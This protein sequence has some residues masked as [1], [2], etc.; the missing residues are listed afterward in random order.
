MAAG[1]A[2]AQLQPTAG[3]VGQDVFH[4][5]QEHGVFWGGRVEAPGVRRPPRPHPHRGLQ[6]LATQVGRLFGEEGAIEG[7]L[8]EPV[9]LLRK[10]FS[11]QDLLYRVRAALDRAE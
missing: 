10:P 2:A 11:I 4:H 6:G 8:G 5:A 7:A 3:E 9:D 1:G